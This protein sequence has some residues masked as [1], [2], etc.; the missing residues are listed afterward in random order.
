M[1][2]LQSLDVDA[3]SVIENPA[4]VE[5]R[6]NSDN[7]AGATGSEGEPGWLKGVQTGSYSKTL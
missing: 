4:A 2:F 1:C 3:F 6:F 5:Q 7:A